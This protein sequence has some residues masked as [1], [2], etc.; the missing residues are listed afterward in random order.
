MNTKKISITLALGV[1]F[2][3]QAFAQIIPFSEIRYWV[4]SGNDSAVLVVSFHSSDLDS[5]TAWGVLFDNSI[6]GQELMEKVA[7]D[8]S[9]FEMKLN[10]QFLDSVGYHRHSGKN[11]ENGFYWGTYTF[12][13]TSWE[14]NSGLIT[15]INQGDYF[16]VSFTDFSP[17]VVPG[18]AIPA[19]NPNRLTTVAFDSLGWFGNGNSH[20]FLVLDFSPEIIGKSYAFGIRFDDSITGLEMLELVAQH[21]TDL[22]INASSFL[23]DLVYR[24]DSGIG[25]MPNFWGTWSGTNLGNWEMNMG[26]STV[27]KNGELFGCAYTNFMPALRPDANELVRLPGQHTSISEMVSNSSLSV[28]PNPFL[29]QLKVN[30]EGDKIQEVTIRDLQGRIVHKHNNAEIVNTSNWKS[31]IYILECKGFASVK[32]IKIMKQ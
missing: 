5:S 3:S 1:L 21:D 20:A 18:N 17:A 32:T 9:N 12:Q 23:S 11:G 28:Y 6:T 22:I 14:S 16:G 24:Q 25:G 2:I 29:N 27:V 4:G 26:I 13:D 31:G 19:F 10:G 30:I 7:L 8:D 15:Q